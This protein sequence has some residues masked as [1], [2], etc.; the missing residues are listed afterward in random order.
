MYINFVI[1]SLEKTKLD[2]GF[3]LG[4]YGSNANKIFLTQKNFVKN[5]L[6]KV[7]ISEK[8]TNI[9]FITYGNS[10]NVNYRFGQLDSKDS[11][12]EILNN[13]I[14]NPNS[15]INVT[16]ALL[17]A[18][19]ELYKEASGSQRYGTRRDALKTFVV[20]IH[21]QI[22]SDIYQKVRLLKD[23][24]VNLIIVAIG[25]NVN[26]YDVNLL[27]KD[28][29]QVIFLDGYD[30]VPEDINKAVNYLYTGIYLST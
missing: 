29:S 30:I 12:L 6:E 4:A 10:A 5:M 2:L 9:G 25:N 7:T 19:T 11:V 24:G 15:G 22:S 27:G 1:T 3:A 26:K 20:F 16:A 23:A 18:R 21:D 13:N 17:A 28:G 8:T 14:R